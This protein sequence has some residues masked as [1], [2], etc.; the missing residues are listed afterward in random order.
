V[1]R[2]ATRRDTGLA[3]CVGAEE[4]DATGAGA[5]ARRGGAAFAFP[6]PL[7]AT[8]CAGKLRYRLIVGVRGAEK[9]S[10]SYCPCPRDQLTRPPSRAII[11]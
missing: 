2:A 3:A 9:L 5:G 10:I 1:T 6:F 8:P 7:A 11:P 4:V